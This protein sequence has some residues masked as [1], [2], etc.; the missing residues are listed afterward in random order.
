MKLPDD[1]RKMIDSAYPDEPAACDCAR[2]RDRLTSWSFDLCALEREI[3][4]REAAVKAGEAEMAAREGWVKACLALCVA[5]L[6]GVWWSGALIAEAVASQ[7][8]R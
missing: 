5:I 1:I 3:K 7:G 2:E 4:K 6:V 8:A